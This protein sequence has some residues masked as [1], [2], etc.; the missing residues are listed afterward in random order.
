MLKMLTRCL[1]IILV[2]V[3]SPAI[4]APSPTA[5]ADGTV[6]SREAWRTPFATRAEWLAFVGGTP[7]GAEAA[8][9]YD[10]LYP[11]GDFNRWTQGR[12]IGISR[13]VYRSGGLAIRGLLLEPRTPGHH[14]V[15]IFNHGGVG[16]WGR[17]VVPDILEMS[18]LAERGYVVLAS[19]FRGEGGSEGKPDMGGGD[20]DDALA[21]IDVAATLPTA[22]VTRVGM[23]G[24]SRGGFTTYGALAKSRR[25][26]AAVIEGGPTDLVHAARRAEFDRHVYPDVIPG[27]AGDKDGV[28]A[29]RSPINWPERLSPGT[30][31]LI[32]HG[33]DDPRVEP[34]DALRMAAALQRLK[35]SY[36][37]KIYEGGGHDLIA[38]M[39]D[40]RAEMDRLFDRYVRDR[41]TPPMNAAVP[42]ADGP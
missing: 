2:A 27:Y 39:V 22:D 7:D 34:T 9:R 26:A 40:V 19:A 13:I 41:V 4:A 33:G 5:L 24:F 30:A 42:V 18:R 38:D 35:R 11:E 36:R 21:L 8:R 12:T 23:W 32:L 20:I 37:L 31:I 15:L 1:A 17:I 14:P 28:L 3:A 6:V 29:R 16:E 10:T 25:I